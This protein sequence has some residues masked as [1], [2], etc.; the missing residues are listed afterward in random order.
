MGVTTVFI[1]LY[2]IDATVKYAFILY[3]YMSKHFRFATSDNIMRNTKN[4][5]KI[6][7]EIFNQ[8]T[9]YSTHWCNNRI[10]ILWNFLDKMDYDMNFEKELW[11]FSHQNL[12]K[13]GRH[14]STTWIL[15]HNIVV[16]SCNTQV[17]FF[18]TWSKQ[19][20]ASHIIR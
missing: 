11:T 14:P 18:T 6:H 3:A 8:H 7:M 5:W 16:Y 1:H 19:H 13:D 15:L 9:N 17:C 2:S 20:F 4:F 10:R 12:F